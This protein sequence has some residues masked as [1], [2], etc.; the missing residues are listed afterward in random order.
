MTD[1]H[2]TQAAVLE[3][4]VKRSRRTLA[5]ALTLLPEGDERL[6][7]AVQSGDVERVRFEAHRFKG[8]C[9]SLGAT[10]L[11][12]RCLALEKAPASPEVAHAF[13]ADLAQEL[14]ALRAALDAE[15]ASLGETR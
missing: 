5:L 13:I 7:A 10:R 4:N 12:Q 3:A 9:L 8:T 1:D 15:L 14:E 11:G 2:A 6:R